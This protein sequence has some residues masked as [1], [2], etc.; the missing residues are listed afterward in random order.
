[1]SR[2]DAKKRI[3][4]LREE[5]ARH[6]HLYYVL[7]GPE[8]SDAE[9]DRLR[10]E[11]EAL[12]ADNPDLVTPDSPTQR[13]GPPPRDD[14]PSVRHVKPLLS[15]ESVMKAADARVFDRRMKKGSR[16]SSST[17]TASSRAPRRAATEPSAR[18]LPPTSARYG[19][20]P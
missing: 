7:D 11:L 8:I 20:C 6:D 19:R 4:R 2:N 3:I 16:S 1:M 18:T 17:R 5:I 10:K 14:L 13:V 15:L 12:E 9:Y